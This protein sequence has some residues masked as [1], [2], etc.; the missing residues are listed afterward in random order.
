MVMNDTLVPVADSDGDG[1][2]DRVEESLGTSPVMYDTDGDGCGDKLEVEREGF[3][4]LVSGNDSDP[5]H[6]YCPQNE[7]TQ[8]SDGDGLLDCEEFYLGT[9]KHRYDS[10][11]DLLPDGLEHRGGSNPAVSNLGIY[12]HD[13]DGASDWEEVWLH[14]LPGVVDDGLEPLPVDEYTY[15]YFIE[16][17][18]PPAGG[19]TCYSFDISN[20][21]VMATAGSD[22]AL[23]PQEGQNDIEVS[24]VQIPREQSDDDPGAHAVVRFGHYQQFFFEPD[25]MVPNRDFIPVLPTDLVVRR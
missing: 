19:V 16:Q 2:P 10:D 18:G 20:I 4:P 3:D 11:S 6:C 13:E 7:R 25:L 22:E 23:G 5:Q 17:D 8:D 9:N 14:R 12:D 1:L 24:F 21:V 15:R